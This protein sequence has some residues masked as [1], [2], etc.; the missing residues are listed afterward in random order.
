[1]KQRAGTQARVLAG[2]PGT[3]KRRSQSG[4]RYWVREHLSQN[5][6]VKFE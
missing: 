1:M 2:A 3:L 5:Y 4:R 6:G